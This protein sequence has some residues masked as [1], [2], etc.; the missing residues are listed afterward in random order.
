MAREKNANDK[1]NI[2]VGYLLMPLYSKESWQ[3]RN[4][5]PSNMR[6][7]EESTIELR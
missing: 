4:S 2:F 3:L 5:W 7:C 1:D 6:D